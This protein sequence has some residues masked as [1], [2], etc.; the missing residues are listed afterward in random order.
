[1]N[2]LQ[3]N[4]LVF[5]KKVIQKFT[6]KKSEFWNWKFYF[7]TQISFTSKLTFLA[8]KNPKIIWTR[9]CHILPIWKIRNLATA[10]FT[11]KQ[12]L[13]SKNPKIQ[14]LR[15]F[16]KLGSICFVYAS[17]QGDRFEAIYRPNWQSLGPSWRGIEVQIDR[18]LPKFLCTPVLQ[19]DCYEKQAR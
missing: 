5:R 6:T 14:K 8:Q 15:L 13:T 2:F 9:K 16:L 7:S 18:L 4:S 12:L 17:L 3:E 10:S 1:M 11:R 19:A